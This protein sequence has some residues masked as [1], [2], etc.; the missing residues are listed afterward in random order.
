MEGIADEV[1]TWYST[2]RSYRMDP[3]LDFPDQ[4]SFTPREEFNTSAGDIHMMFLT[5]HDTPFAE[6]CDDPWF[7]AH[8]AVQTPYNRTLYMS[9]NLMNPV[10]CVEQVCRLFRKEW[11]GN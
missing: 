10:G 5:P 3:R 6:P 11:P 9:D 7:S 8:K 2:S 4:S 1:L